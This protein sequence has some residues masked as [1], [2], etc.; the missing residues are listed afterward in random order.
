VIFDAHAHSVDEYC[1]ENGALKVTMVDDVFEATS[2]RPQTGTAATT[3]RQTDR[4]TD[5]RDGNSVS[6]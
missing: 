4:Q 2:Q 6:N 5:S 3:Y 1:E